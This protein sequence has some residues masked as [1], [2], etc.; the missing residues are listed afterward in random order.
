MIGNLSSL[1]TFPDEV[2]YMGLSTDEFVQAYGNFLVKSWADADLQSRFKGDPSGVLAEFGMDSGGATVEV[3]APGEPGEN[4]TP[5]SQAELWNRGVESG[6]IQFYYPDSPQ[7][8]ATMELSDDELEA[9]AG[10]GDVNC[11]CTP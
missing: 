8:G 7:R 9:V 2:C 10:G 6:S 4:A 3:V 11:C 5:E 1:L